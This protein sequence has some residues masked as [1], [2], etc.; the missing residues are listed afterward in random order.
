MGRYT[1]EDAMAGKKPPK[2]WDCADAVADGWGKAELDAYMRATVMTLDEF[3]EYRRAEWPETLPAAETAKPIASIPAGQRVQQMKDDRQDQRPEATGERVFVTPTPTIGVVGQI[4]GIGRFDVELEAWLRGQSWEI[5]RNLLSEELELHLSDRAVPMSD[6]R[7]AEIGFTVEYASNGKAP[8]KDKISDAVALIGERRA[9]HPVREY[10]AGL[11]WDGIERLNGWLVDYLGAEDTPLNRAFA[12]K[13][14]CAA[15][16]RVMQ[17]GCKFDSML[18]LEGA[19]DLG[20]SSAIRALCPNGR[21]FTDQLEIGADPKVTIEKTAG[22]WIVEMP[23]LDGL[24][25][26]DTNRVKSFITTTH[27]RA[28][29]AYSRFAVTR[30]RQFVLFGTT[31]ESRYLTDTTGNRRFWIVKVNK[32]D[33]VGIAA[34]RDQ[35]WAEAVQA[36]LAENLWLDDPALKSAAADAAREASDFGPWAELLGDRLPDDGP[37]KIEAI[38]IWRMV[39]FEGAETINRLTKAHHAHLKAAM[40]GLGFERRDSG[41]RNASGKKVRAY[42]RGDLH[43]AKWWRPGDPVSDGSVPFADW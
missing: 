2:G 42:V 33:P 26:R 18:V 32:A 15:V 22:A 4:T 37:L 5:K 43:E 10:F 19:Q 20:K 35:L 3:E 14:L 39:G 30:P 25:R 38:D 23:E 29:L 9:Y 27:D 17:P 1:F 13:I 24:G 7:L 28:R 12:R 40:I 36:E 31:N 6:E 34:V 8:A 21:W 41:I 16:R 11:R